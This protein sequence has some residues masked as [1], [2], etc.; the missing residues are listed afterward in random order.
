M[1]LLLK[2]EG[3][4]PINLEIYLLFIYLIIKYS[5]KEEANTLIIITRPEIQSMINNFRDS[6]IWTGEK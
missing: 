6:Y 4:G 5:K 2:I 1:K 3:L